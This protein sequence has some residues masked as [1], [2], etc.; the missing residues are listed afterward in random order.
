MVLVFA[1]AAA[2][3]L[4]M[5]VLTDNRSQDYAQ[6]DRAVLV[7]QSV[8]EQCKHDAD[9]YLE[10]SDAVYEDGGWTLSADDGAYLIRIVY[11][12]TESKYLW[13]ATVSV[14]SAE[15]ECLFSLPIAGQNAGEVTAND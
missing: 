3:C 5:F 6:K 9:A 14:F 4:K 12:E 7:A 10:E 8:A 15:G 1:M 13:R 11:E 2:M